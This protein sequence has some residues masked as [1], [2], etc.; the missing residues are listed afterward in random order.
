MDLAKACSLM[1]ALS[2]LSCIST[3]A[4]LNPG[5]SQSLF[6]DV[7][8]LQTF[9][10]INL[11][12]PEFGQIDG[13]NFLCFFNLPLV[14]A[15]LLLQFINQFLHPFIIL[16]VLILPESQFFDASLAFPKIF[17]SVTQST[18]FTIQ[19]SFNI[20][21]SGFQFSNHFSAPLDGISFGL[22]QIDLQFMCTVLQI[23][24]VPFKTL[25]IF[26]FNS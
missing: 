1:S 3:W 10:H 14:G 16:T 9:L 12:L 8:P 11:G 4:F 13:S 23:L 18:L 26:L 22:I 5:F 25:R 17:G 19:F 6:A 7:S 15:N 21:G 2:K 20:L 24:T